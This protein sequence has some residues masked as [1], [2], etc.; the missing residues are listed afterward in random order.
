[1]SIR[2]QRPLDQGIRTAASWWPQVL[3]V[4]LLRDTASGL[5]SYYTLFSTLKV[6]KW[7]DNA[8]KLCVLVL[9]REDEWGVDL[10]ST[11]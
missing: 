3:L 9:A 8:L 11:S 4:N 7:H 1:M 6:S 2:L 10:E 5:V